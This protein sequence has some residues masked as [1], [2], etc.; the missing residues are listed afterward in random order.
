M[1][2]VYKFCS[3]FET[4]SVYSVRAKTGTLC[5]APDVFGH[6]KVVLVSSVLGIIVIA[7]AGVQVRELE[8][9]LSLN[10]NVF[11]VVVLVLIIHNAIHH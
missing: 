9:V 2:S 3:K 11:P 6:G 4:M 8:M 7:V 10:A 1:W 5:E